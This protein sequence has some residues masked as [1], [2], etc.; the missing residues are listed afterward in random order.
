M[1]KVMEK[2]RKFHDAEDLVNSDGNANTGTA[3]KNAILDRMVLNKR[4]KEGVC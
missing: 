4:Q 1:K 3:R 2:Y